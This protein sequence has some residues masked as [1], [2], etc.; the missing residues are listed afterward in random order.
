M[1]KYTLMVLS[2]VLF[3]L[4]AVGFWLL[5]HEVFYLYNFII[6]GTSIGVGLGLWPLLPK[7]KK[8]IARKLCQ[9]LVGGYMFLG[10][11]LGF[12]SLGD[13]VI[14]PENMQIEGFW[15]LLLGGV[16]AASVMHY[17]IA[18]IAGPFL[19]GRTWCGWTCWTA[20]ILDV[21]PWQK[22]PGRLHPRWGF[23]RYVFFILSAGLVFFLVFVG[24]YTAQS[25][26]GI[27]DLTGKIHLDY[28]Y[29]SLLYV[30][31]FWW[32]AAGN[33]VYYLVGIVLAAVLRDNRAFC[34]YVCPIT[35]FLKLGGRFSLLRIKAK[36]ECTDCGKCESVCPMDVKI[37][38]Y[39]GKGARVKSTECILCMTCVNSCPRN[40][41]AP[42]FG[43]DVTTKEYLNNRGG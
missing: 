12:V 39:V 9:A 27:V 29:K 4:I 41:L 28:V 11:G 42:S 40:I 31:Q 15:F 8:H 43:F 17:T 18:K 35:V 1:K 25:T 23:L 34:K 7:N 5:F 3:Y 16:F 30:P 37:T 36:G 19:F 33:F 2:L 32:F 20:G 38:E 21:L 14:R 22:S 13:G 26:A 6:I 10:L 24:N